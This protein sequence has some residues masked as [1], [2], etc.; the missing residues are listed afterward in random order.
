MNQLANLDQNKLVKINQ[1]F[2]R[3]WA[4]VSM[5]KNCTKKCIPDY[6]NPDLSG[7]EKN[8]IDR[9][10]LKYFEANTVLSKLYT[11]EKLGHST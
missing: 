1:D 5:Q 2:I 9:C 4:L 10:V 8:C 11:E 6:Q 3:G 7:G